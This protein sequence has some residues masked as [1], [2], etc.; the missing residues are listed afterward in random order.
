MLRYKQG[1]Y[2]MAG[3]W[4]GK[5]KPP[6]SAM[7]KVFSGFMSLF[8]DGFE[9]RGVKI[10]LRLVIASADKPA[11]SYLANTMSCIGEFGC[12]FC[13]SCTHV[14]FVDGKRHVHH[15]FTKRSELTIRN[16]MLSLAIRY[17]TSFKVIRNILCRQ[18]AENFSDHEFGFH[19]ASAMQ[20]FI[21]F[22]LIWGFSVDYMHTVC[23]GVVKSL[24][25]LQ[26]SRQSFYSVLS[27]HGEL[28]KKFCDGLIV[29]DYVDASSWCLTSTGLWKAKDYHFFLFGYSLLL[30]EYLCDT[31][32]SA[33]LEKVMINKTF[34]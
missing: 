31:T 11:R 34:I 4:F 15:K 13:L 19:G 32:D 24:V 25:N 20:N 12:H 23:L 30:L 33:H 2:I 7:E 28:I 27:I 1:N 5:K 17:L 3:L 8:D 10:Y 9:A 16:E 21:D 18:S 14:S 26:F 6:T 22:N 29:P